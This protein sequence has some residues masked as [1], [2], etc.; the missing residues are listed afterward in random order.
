MACNKRT[1]RPGNWSVRIIEIGHS[2]NFR[3]TTAIRKRL[4]SGAE[5]ME[6]L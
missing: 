1:G 3:Q 6:S 2:A 5:G 4:L